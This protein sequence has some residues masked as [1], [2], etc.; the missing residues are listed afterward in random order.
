MNFLL[1]ITERTP[2]PKGYH[3]TNTYHIFCESMFE[4]AE[5]IESFELNFGCLVS[6]TVVPTHSTYDVDREAGKL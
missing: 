5:Q 4:V 6:M 2:M 1:T 3:D